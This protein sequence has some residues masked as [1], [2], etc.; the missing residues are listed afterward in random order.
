VTRGDVGDIRSDVGALDLFTVSTHAYV[1]LRV[2]LYNSDSVSV[3][4]LAGAVTV[5]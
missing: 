5:V 3:T 2:T 4:L 1:V